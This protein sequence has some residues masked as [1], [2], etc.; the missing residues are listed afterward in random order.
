MLKRFVNSLSEVDPKHVDLYVKVANGYKLSV[1]DD[2]EDEP[3]DDDKSKDS[4]RLKQFRQK[5]IELMKQIAEL[6]SKLEG[7]DVEMLEAGKKAMQKARNE[8]ERALLAAGRFEDVFN[9]RLRALQDDFAKKEKGHSEL[10]TKEQA[11]VKKLHDSLK[12]TK[13]ESDLVREATEAKLRLRPSAVP[14]FV[15]RGF[16]VFDLDEDGNL[17][18]LDGEGNPMLTKDQKPYGKRDFIMQLVDDAP[19]LLEDGEGAGLG[20]GPKSRRSSGVVEIDSDDVKGFGNNIEA[21]AKGKV[22]VRVR[23]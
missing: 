18:A 2:A 21:I 6:S 7:V 14:D 9:L 4:E 20:G 12:R 11:R 16:E 23:K 5:N 3:D 13:I 19:H 15:R 1:E 8:E 22:N 10:L 17:V